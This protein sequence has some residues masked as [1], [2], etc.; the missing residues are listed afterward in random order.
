MNVTANMHTASIAPCIRGRL[1]TLR[2]PSASLRSVLESGL[3]RCRQS[4]AE[5]TPK[6]SDSTATLVV[7]FLHT[8]TLDFHLPCDTLVRRP[9]P[10][11]VPT[12]SQVAR[13]VCCCSEPG[14]QNYTAPGRGL[15]SLVRRRHGLESA[16]PCSSTPPLCLHPSTLLPVLLLPFFFRPLR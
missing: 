3:P 4:R 5:C 10:A 12:L 15:N 14:D 9:H 16:P 1:L 6:C 11:L 7:S 8:L 2:S 13:S